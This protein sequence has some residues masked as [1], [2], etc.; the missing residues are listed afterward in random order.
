MTDLIVI[1]DMQSDYQAIKNLLGIHPG[2]YR[3]R[4]Y[5]R[6][7]AVEDTI[8]VG[9]AL[10]EYLDK[11]LEELKRQNPVFIVDISFGKSYDEERLGIEISK[12]LFNY[13]EGWEPRVVVLTGQD[14]QLWFD[15]L[16][17]MGVRRFVY[18]GNLEYTLMPALN[19]AR[20]NEPFLGAYIPSPTIG[21]ENL[22]VQQ[23]VIQLVA[24]GFSNTAIMKGKYPS[25][26]PQKTKFRQQH[27]QEL[28]NINV[29]GHKVPGV[30][31]WNDAAYLFYSLR[32]RD[33][34]VI[35]YVERLCKIR[36]KVPVGD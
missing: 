25:V 30:T 4:E 5:I 26:G 2:N 23:E 28:S 24:M 11:N 22:Q 27:F 34:K 9:G 15:E 31:Q 1:D 35:E 10:D 32:M 8:L 17:E 13:Q 29:P 14:N 19:A 16:Y 12:F 7:P 3:V 21:T 20:K 6:H 18:K 33:A 36:I